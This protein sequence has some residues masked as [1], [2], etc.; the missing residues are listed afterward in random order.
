M[1]TASGLLEELPQGVALADA[2]GAGARVRPAARRR[3][4]RKA[5]LGGNSVGHRPRL[6]GPRHAGARRVPALPDGRR[7]QHQGAGPPLVPAGLLPAPPRSTAAT[8]PW[9]T[10]RR[11]SRSCVTTARRCS[12]P[13]PARTPTRPGRSRRGSRSRPGEGEAASNAVPLT[14]LSRYDGRRFLAGRSELAHGHGGCSS[15]GR[16]PGCGPGCRGFKSRHSPGERDPVVPAVLG[17][18]SRR[19]VSSIGRAAD[20]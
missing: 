5:P 18:V 16:A 13:S 7:V 3:R 20:S 17:L 2:A 1:H 11:A 9:P 15:A 12:C 19:A 10:S 8:G 6:P 14:R 4:P